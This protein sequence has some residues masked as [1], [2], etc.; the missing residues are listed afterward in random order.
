MGQTPAKAFPWPTPYGQ[1]PDSNVLNQAI[2]PPQAPQNNFLPLNPASAGPSP[3][4]PVSSPS[5]G[6][7]GQSNLSKRIQPMFLNR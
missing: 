4:N 2:A 5:G 3:L 7:G 1:S 6:Q